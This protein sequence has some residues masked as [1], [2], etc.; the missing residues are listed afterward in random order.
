MKR[1]AATGAFACIIRR[2]AEFGALRIGLILLV[3]SL[4]A[5]QQDKVV[6]PLECGGGGQYAYSHALMPDTGIDAGQTQLVLLD[7][8]DTTE[9][10]HLYVKR[11]LVPPQ[12]DTG[13]TPRV[14]LITTDGRVLLDTVGTR[15]NTAT[16]KYDAPNWYVADTIRSADVRKAFYDAMTK[17]LL[18]LELWHPGASAPGS[19]VPVLL[20][21]AGVHPFYICT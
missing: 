17:N 11:E 1:A 6:N 15:W 18:W 14:R 13:A 9:V 12:P 21:E 19:R 2:Q 20:D 8:P 10:T 16:S 5:C 7:Q 3:A 4:G